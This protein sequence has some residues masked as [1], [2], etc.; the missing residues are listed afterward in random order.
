MADIKNPRV[1]Y[2]YPG[3]PIV[4]ALV[5]MDTYKSLDEA[6]ARKGEYPSALANGNI[7]GAGGNV[8][9][10]LDV[11][12]HISR[13]MTVEDAFEWADGLWAGCDDQ[14]HRSG[15]EQERLQSRWRRGQE[16]ADDLKEDFRK[17]VADW[18][19]DAPVR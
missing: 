13:G 8:Y 15:S 17:K 18:F 5:I 9:N 19:A 1:E 11:L 2:V 10:A 14:K 12:T 16:Q 3:H 6:H 4:I 7:P